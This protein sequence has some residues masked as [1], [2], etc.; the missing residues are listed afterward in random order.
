MQ[1]ICGVSMEGRRS[2]AVYCSTACGN[3]YRNRTYL[4]K[5]GM[6]AEFQEM[7][8][9]RNIKYRG[10]IH[11]TFMSHKHRAKQCGI[12]FNLTFS[13]WWSLWEPLWDGRAGDNTTYL[14][15]C[16]TGDTGPYELGN[17]RIDTRA[18]NNR[19]AL[20]NRVT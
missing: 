14:V 16:R 5:H 3:K 4:A 7:Q 6:T 17:V 18:N 19:E 12:V 1:C 11:G 15:M 13:E 2:N 20:C 8:K 9:A 10:T